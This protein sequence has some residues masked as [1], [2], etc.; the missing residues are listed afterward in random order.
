[1]HLV[2]NA[3]AAPAIDRPRIELVEHKPQ[4]GAP[5]VQMVHLPLAN[6]HLSGVGSESP[7]MVESGPVG[8]F[9]ASS[10][11]AG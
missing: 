6:A 4:P 9:D 11:E 8:K 3:Y 5:R 1:V 7:L 2:E 10:D